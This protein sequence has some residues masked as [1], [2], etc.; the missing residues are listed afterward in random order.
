MKILSVSDVITNSS[1]E[2]F[3]INKKD[4]EKLSPKI[5]KEFE[6]VTK[7]DFI[8]KLLDFDLEGVIEV[9][10]YSRLFDGYNHDV[11]IK[12]RE[13]YSDEEISNFFYPI[14]KDIFDIAFFEEEDDYSY[15][16]EQI[17]LVLNE[18]KDKKV[19]YKTERV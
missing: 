19:E 5:K 18:L 1:S 13:V 17:N 12:L 10:G 4:L 8:S 9:L 7:K 6:I 11:I 15:G 3:V 14:I 2:V 16:Y